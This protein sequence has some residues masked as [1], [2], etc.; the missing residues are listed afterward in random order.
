M[1][2]LENIKKHDFEGERNEKRSLKVSF[3]S[4]YSFNDFSFFLQFNPFNIEIFTAS[5]K[6]LDELIEKDKQREKDGFPKRIRIGKIVKP[7][8]GNKTKV[9]VVPSTTEPKF[10]HDD[11]ITED[12]EESTG[13]SGKGEEGEVIGKQKADP[14]QG[15]GSGEGAGQG[16]SEEHDV[17]ADAE[18]LGK[19]L[20]QEFQLPNLKNKGNKRSLTKYTYTLTDRNRE[21]G[22]L[23]DKKETLRSIVK[24]NIM[25]GNI[26]PDEL[27]DPSSLIINPKDKIYR[28]M[29]KEKDFEAQA[30]VFFMRDY[31]GSMS[32]KP[33]EVVV[34]QH[35]MVYSWLMY[36]YQGNVETRFIVHDTEAKQVPDF[37]TYYRYQVAGGTYV[38]P[39]FELL[40]KIIEDEQLSK[41]YNIYIFYGT[42]GDDWEN[43]GKKMLDELKKAVSVASRCG[44]TIAKNAWAK[45]SKTT[46][47]KYLES[48]GLLTEKKDYLR[49]DALE[50]ETASDE[51][52]VKSI[53]KLIS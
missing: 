33:A 36:Q 45:N 8:P 5:L 3:D 10:Y 39:A 6:T 49:I 9:V 44:I 27:F 46:V 42:D 25:L 14:H 1:D 21:F 17:T 13:G 32:G 4:L 29:S 53:K 43:D 34:S 18:E 38:F 22:Q 50:A 48:S 52:I 35:L 26:N 30:V 47:E 16:D 40:N 51:D 2:E 19:I 31:S 7:L 15:E 24:T 37:Y 23:L 12:E 20:T 41:D 28:I 11:S